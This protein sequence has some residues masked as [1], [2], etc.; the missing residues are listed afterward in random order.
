MSAPWD[1][2]REP[3]NFVGI[4][5]PLTLWVLL[6]VSIS[7]LGIAI[8]ALKKKSSPKLKWVAGAFGLF[9]IKSALLVIDY[10]FSPGNFMNQAIIGFFDLCVMI[11]F[12]IAL[13]RK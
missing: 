4:L 9:F 5:E 3:V 8:L 2:L 13:F 1:F 7:M 12:F 10:Y 11:A 6:V